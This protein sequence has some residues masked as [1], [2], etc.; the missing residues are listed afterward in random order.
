MRFVFIGLADGSAP[1]F[2]DEV[3]TEIAAARIFSGGRRHRG[4]VEHLLPAGARW[5]EIAP[6]M[7]DVFQQYEAHAKPEVNGGPSPDSIVVF[8][9]GD[10]LFFGFAATVALRLPAAE[11]RIYP[12]FNSLQT[13]A[14]RVAMPYHDMRTISLT[15]RPWA[16]L[17][18]ALIEGSSKIGILTDSTHT[19]AAIARRMTDYG[20]TGYEMIV[21]ERLGNETDERISK[22]SL[23]EAAAEE[24]AMPNCVIVHGT[25]RRPRMGT[26]DTEFSL[27]DGR[28]A[29]ITKM[30][31]RLTTLASLGLEQARTLWDVGF[32]TGSVSIEARLRFPHLQIHAFEIRPEGA[33]LMEVNSRRHGAPG[34]ETH[35]GDFLKADLDSLPTP[36]AVFIGGH[37]GRLEEIVAAAARRLTPGGTVVFN[38]VS[39]DSSARFESACTATG[40][41]PVCA[42]RI[43]VDEHNPINIL[44]ACKPPL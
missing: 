42:T 39:A 10:P 12:V 20:Y 15:G 7:D 24:F 14:H 34:I 33:R 23:P 19:P 37:G 40:L 44:K 25:P 29:M 9:S 13:L 30:P 22:L 31:V 27:L 16:Q 26:P 43:T 2:S 36:D 28:P 1:R 32:C 8:A 21:G 41:T 17:D 35:I 6:P 11:L 3:M 18:R 4:L 38:S 5:I